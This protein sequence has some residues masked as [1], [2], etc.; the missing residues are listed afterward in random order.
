MPQHRGRSEEGEG[1]GEVDHKQLL[2]IRGTAGNVY[3]VRYLTNLASAVAVGKEKREKSILF[4]K[5]YHHAISMKKECNGSE[6]VP[7][8][9][10]ISVS[11]MTRRHFVTRLKDGV[12]S[13]LV[14]NGEIRVAKGRFL[15]SNLLF[16]NSFF[17]ISVHE[18]RGV[19]NDCAL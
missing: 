8:L 13:F 2:T 19:D 4:Q 6:K 1:D 7:F 12:V 18:V 9:K 10:V 16:W 15:S 17:G 5:R 14:K 3:K 11:F